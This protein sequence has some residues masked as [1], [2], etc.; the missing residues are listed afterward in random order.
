MMKPGGK[1]AEIAALGVWSLAAGNI[2]VYTVK[3]FKATFNPPPLSVW[4]G[5]PEAQKNAKTK[6]APETKKQQ[7]EKKKK[8]G[9]L[10]GLFENVNPFKQK[11]HESILQE[12][13]HILNPTEWGPTS[14][15]KELDEPFEKGLDNILKGL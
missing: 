10:G 2:I 14:G 5:G 3:T 4:Q 6:T 15:Q 1:L 12:A 13:L 11:N 7:E 9:L 8:K